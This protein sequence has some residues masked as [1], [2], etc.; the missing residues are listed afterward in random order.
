MAFDPH[1][2]SPMSFQCVVVGVVGLVDQ[3]ASGIES[4]GE[5]PESGVGRQLFPQSRRLQQTRRTE[6]SQEDRRRLLDELAAVVAADE[7]QVH[8]AARLQN[9]RKLLNR[10]LQVSRPVKGENTEKIV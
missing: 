2:P 5:K 8:L 3:Q 4:S 10:A 1:P 7:K 6:V 9:P